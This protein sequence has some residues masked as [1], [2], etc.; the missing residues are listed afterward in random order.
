VYIYIEI[1][2]TCFGINT[3]SSGSLQLC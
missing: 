2:P 1:S 3:P